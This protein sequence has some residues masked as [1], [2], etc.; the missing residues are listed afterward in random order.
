MKKLTRTVLGAVLLAGSATAVLAAGAM[1]P[2]AANQSQLGLSQPTQ[3]SPGTAEDTWSQDVATRMNQPGTMSAS[4]QKAR[5][6]PSATAGDSAQSNAQQSGAQPPVP[7]A[8]H[9]K[10]D[11]VGDRMTE[12]LN[13]LGSGGYTDIQNLTPQGQQFTA[14]AML[15]GRSVSVT[16][17]P[18]T[19]QVINRS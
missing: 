2:S 9:G 8:R 13:L 15:N 3:N 10:T 16:V 19:R 6:N 11:E 17:D 18:Q 1:D 12:A 14:N 4:R 7:V 5:Q